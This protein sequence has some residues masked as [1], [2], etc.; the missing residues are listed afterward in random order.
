VKG[1]SIIFKERKKKG[2]Q[3]QETEDDVQLV[4]IE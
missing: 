1:Y 4:I 3:G 2:R